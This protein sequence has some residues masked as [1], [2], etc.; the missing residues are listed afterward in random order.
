[1]L[2]NEVCASK[3]TQKLELGTG[4]GKTTFTVKGKTSA[5]NPSTKEAI[6]LYGVT[7]MNVK[8]VL[9]KPLRD[10]QVAEM[11]DKIEKAFA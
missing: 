2:G 7:G 8:R 6:D 3:E 11:R 10:G 1:M 9:P 4:D 5:I